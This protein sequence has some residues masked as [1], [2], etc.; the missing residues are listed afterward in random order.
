ME[1]MIYTMMMMI[2]MSTD[3]SPTAPLI[4]LPVASTKAHH[5]QATQVWGM[6]S[7]RHHEVW[8]V[9]FSCKVLCLIY[10]ACGQGSL[11]EVG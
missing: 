9:L 11:V 7:Q 1:N 3:G 2:N 5:I 10:W 6:V 8:L 4:F